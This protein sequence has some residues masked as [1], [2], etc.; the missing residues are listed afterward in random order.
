MGGTGGILSVFI[1][2][3]CGEVLRAEDGAEFFA[4]EDAAA[5]DGDG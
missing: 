1:C 3:I 2:V 4:E 5:G